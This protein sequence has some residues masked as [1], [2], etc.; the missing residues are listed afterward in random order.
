MRTL[1]DFLQSVPAKILFSGLRRDFYGPELS[2]KKAVRLRLE[3]E[4]CLDRQGGEGGNLFLVLIGRN[5]SIQIRD[6][7]DG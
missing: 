3:P 1:G 5:V 7:Y 4:R 2:G 6:D